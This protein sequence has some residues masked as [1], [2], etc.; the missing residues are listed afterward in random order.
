[1]AGFESRIR[2]SRSSSTIPVSAL[3][4]VAS[5]RASARTWSRLASNSAAC[6][7]APD[8]TTESSSIVVSSRSPK[9]P[10]LSP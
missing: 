7:M 5:K 8:R 9:A 10:A 1:M 4:N 3:A 6:A 2:P